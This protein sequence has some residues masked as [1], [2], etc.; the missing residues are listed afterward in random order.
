MI[1]LNPKLVEEKKRK[2]TEN[3]HEF[4]TVTEQIVNV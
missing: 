1:K 2:I 4:R 3:Q